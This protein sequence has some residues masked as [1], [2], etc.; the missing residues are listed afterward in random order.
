MDVTGD[1]N[2]YP[3]TCDWCKLRLASYSAYKIQMT[4]HDPLDYN[5]ACEE[6]YA[7]AWS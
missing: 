7:K 5:W 2:G 6:C 3:V 4:A 1:L